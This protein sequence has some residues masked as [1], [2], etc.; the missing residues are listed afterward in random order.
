MTSNKDNLTQPLS[1]I[2]KLNIGLEDN[3]A[4]HAHTRQ[5]EQVLQA[6]KAQQNSQNDVKP[7]ETKK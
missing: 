7:K 4:L 2:E 1:I 5:A 6:L 3:S